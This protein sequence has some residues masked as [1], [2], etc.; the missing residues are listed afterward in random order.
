MADARLTLDG[1][2]EYYESSEP[3]GE[4]VLV[5]EGGKRPEAAEFWRGLD[6]PAHVRHYTD[7][8]MPERDA[9][10]AAARDRGVPKNVV[11]NEYVKSKNE[12]K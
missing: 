8:G 6:V 11:Y 4:Y 3:R 9:V 10:K 7:A 1:A 2:V 5:L 12:E